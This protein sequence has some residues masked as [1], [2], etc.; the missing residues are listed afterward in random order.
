M[1]YPIFLLYNRTEKCPDILKGV[2]IFII[3]Q[4]F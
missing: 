1:E 4:T 3:E 2:L